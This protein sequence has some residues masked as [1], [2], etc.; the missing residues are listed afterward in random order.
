M[1]LCRSRACLSIN[2]RLHKTSKDGSSKC[3]A[4][5]TG[6]ELGALWGVV[7]NIATSEKPTLDQA[8]GLGGGYNARSVLVAM[9]SGKDLEAATYLA[10]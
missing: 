5:Y 6:E 8:E 1:S 10:G 7:F 2:L 3:D 9:P 4:L